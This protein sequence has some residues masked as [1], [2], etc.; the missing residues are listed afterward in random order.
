MSAWTAVLLV[1]TQAGSSPAAAPPP[2]RPEIAAEVERGTRAYNT[3][4]LTYYQAALAP[5]TS[6]VADDGMVFTG[7]DHVVELFRRIFARPQKAH[8][9]V[10]DLVTGGQG[11]M[12]WARFSWELSG[13]D[14]A[15]PGVATVVFQRAATGWQ[16]VE[17]HNTART[18]HAMPHAHAS[19]GVSPSP[20][21]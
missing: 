10:S 12:G 1:A 20:A 11:D 2:S 19:P 16:V 13:I 9:E 7:K 4:D 21:H 3:Q 14:R 18:G 15:R 5:D 6:Y 8:L 17:I